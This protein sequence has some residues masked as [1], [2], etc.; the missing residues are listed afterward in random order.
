[1][2]DVCVVCTN[3]SFSWPDDTQVFRD[4]SFTVPPGRTG[5]VAPNGAGKSTL[6]RL[7]AGDLVPTGGGVMVEGVLGY[8][9]QNLPLTGDLTVAEVLGVAPALTA[10]RAIEAG[11]ASE[12]NFAAVGDDWDVEERS[13]A[14]LDRL[15]LGEVALDR[16][17]DTLSGGQA[18]SLGLAAQL[19]RRPDVLLLD[20]PTNNLD[21]DARHRLYAVLESWS[22]CL[23]LVSHD[24]MLLDRMDR[25]AELDGGQLR[26]YGGNFTAYEEASRAAREL[27]ERQVRSAELEVK[28]EKR[29]MQQARERAERRAGNAARNLGNAGLAR[30]VAGGL[31]RSAQESAGRAQQ[32]HASRVGDAQARL[33]EAGRALREDQTLALEL[34]ETDVPAGRTLVEGQRMQVRYGNRTLFAGEGVDLTIRGPERIALTGPNGVGKSTLLRLLLGDLDPQGGQVRRADGRVAYLSQRLDLLDADRTVLDNLTAYAPQRQQSERMNLLA[35]FLFRGARAQLPVGVL[36]G[37]E[38]LRAT[39]ACV[40]YAQ[41]APHLLLLDEPTN[42]LDLVSV[43]QLENAL[44]AYRGAFVV[45]SHDER[46]LRDIGVNRWLRLDGSGLR[47]IPAPEP[48]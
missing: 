41:P 36:S 23:L 48:D 29:E 31:K 26:L 20:E 21:I 22:G 40:L 13:H 46:F 19:L 8:L 12:E 14:E 4:L 6:L 1:M 7:I 30:I 42:N 39:L 11:D 37:G 15:G 45:V 25:I 10:L 47:E 35:R 32:A 33:D 28:R 5:L 2:S 44:N 3:L 38:L 24:R 43:G 9:P 18:V 34:P 16:R 27:A 17:L